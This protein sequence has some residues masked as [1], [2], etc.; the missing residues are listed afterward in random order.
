MRTVQDIAR[1]NCSAIDRASRFVMGSHVREFACAF[2]IVSEEPVL[3][4]K[5]GEKVSPN[6][7]AES[8]VRNAQKLL[9]NAG[10]HAYM[11]LA[12]VMKDCVERSRLDDGRLQLDQLPYECRWNIRQYLKIADIAKP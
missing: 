12:G 3:R 2:E 6:E 8:M 11:E 4:M 5:V 7:E 10:L 9:R 1:R